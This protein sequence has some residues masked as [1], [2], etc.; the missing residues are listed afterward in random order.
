MKTVSLQEMYRAANEKT[1]AIWAKNAGI[2]E[3]RK[4]NYYDPLK[5]A[6]ATGIQPPVPVKVSRLMNELKQRN[7]EDPLADILPAHG[8]H[9][10]FLPLTLPLYHVNEPLPAKVEQLTT[11][12]PPFDAKKII[13]RNLRLVAL[14]GQL[15]LAGIPE[16]PAIALR[17]SFCE[18]VLES[19]WKNELLQRHHGS[20]LPAPFWHS[21]LLRYN[22]A[23]LPAT[24]RQFFLKRQDIDFGDVT[25]EL[26]SARVNYNWTQCYPLRIN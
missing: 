8:F 1:L 14:P 26:I 10:T 20:A 12:W 18:K 17:Q 25:G 23:F 9:F 7:Q 5:L 21:T 4:E 19:D 15:L 22:A 6:L 11:I 16:N 2:G 3:V 24:L 13:I